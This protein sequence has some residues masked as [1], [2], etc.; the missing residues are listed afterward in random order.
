MLRNTAHP[1]DHR[2]IV[3][4]HLRTLR[5][6]RF[7]SLRLNS[8]HMLL[9]KVQQTCSLELI[10]QKISIFFSLFVIIFRSRSF[11]WTTM[12]TVLLVLWLPTWFYFFDCR[13]EVFAHELLFLMFSERK[14]TSIR[15]ISSWRREL[16]KLRLKQ[17]LIR[18]PIW[19][20][21]IFIFKFF[22]VKLI[23][24]IKEAATA[25]RLSEVRRLFFWLEL[26]F[27]AYNDVYF[28]R[29]DYILLDYIV[30]SVVV[31]NRAISLIL[32]FDVTKL[33]VT[34]RS[35]P[36]LISTLT[37]FCINTQVRSVPR[38]TW[39]T[40]SF[41]PFPSS[42]VIRTSPDRLSTPT[43]NNRWLFH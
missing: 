28:L 37:L 43:V 34:S 6:L 2:L 10:L 17:R 12:M 14:T 15:G 38:V 22:L 42:K 3:I 4:Y 11:R 13:S 8:T 1:L 27:I 19:A 24:K 20:I 30:C 31:M 33:D 21:C 39:H 7:V 29:F 40:T 25:L 9:P 32:V 26:V 18:R 36:K 5:K 35:L 16:A 41:A 23:W